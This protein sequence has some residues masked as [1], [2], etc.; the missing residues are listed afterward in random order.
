MKL[1]YEEWTKENPIDWNDFN[2]DEE[3]GMIAERHYQMYLW[4]CMKDDTQ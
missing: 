1:T 4:E 3:D 2:D